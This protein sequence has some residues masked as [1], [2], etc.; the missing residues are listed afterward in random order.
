MYVTLQ[1]NFGLLA[2]TLVVYGQPLHLIRKK[3]DNLWNERGNE[4]QG[5]KLT[6]DTEFSTKK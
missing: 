1:V 4:T 6:N 3:C 2:V 5:E